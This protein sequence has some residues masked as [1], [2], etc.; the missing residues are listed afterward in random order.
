MFSPDPLPAYFRS[1]SDGLSII[2][3]EVARKNVTVQIEG[4]NEIGVQH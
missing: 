1:I 4:L 2:F 3:Y